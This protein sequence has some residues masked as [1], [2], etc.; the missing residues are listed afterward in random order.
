[1]AA[2][3]I[4]FGVRISARCA[5]DLGRFAPCGDLIPNVAD[6]EQRVVSNKNTAP[7]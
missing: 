4:Y 2:V 5:C 6:V 7:N 3:R 1:M